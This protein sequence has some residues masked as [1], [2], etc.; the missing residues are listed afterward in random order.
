MNKTKAIVDFS[1]YPAVELGPVARTIHDQMSVNAA[2]FP[3]PPVSM[4]ALLALIEDYEAKLAAK[5]SGARADTLAF[6][7]A[8]KALEP[9]LGLLGGYVNS[10]AQGDEAIVLLSGI[11]SYGTGRPADTAPPAAPQD[12]RLSHGTLSTTI[13]LRYRPARARSMNEVQTTEGNPNAEDGWVDRGVFGGGRA[14]VTRLTVGTTIWVRVRT[15]GL[16][17]VMGAW[18]DPAKITVI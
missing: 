11:P 6:Q 5:A 13:N 9:A 7:L 1:N 18:S 12:V 16:N 3:S 17:G 10:V 8:R 4:A 2:T 15:A 14:T